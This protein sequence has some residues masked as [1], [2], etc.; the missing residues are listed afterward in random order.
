MILENVIQ[1]ST[2][3]PAFHKYL[4]GHLEKLENQVVFPALRLQMD[5]SK[6]TNNPCESMN[7][8]LK[9]EISWQPKSAVELI[10]ILQQHIRA[11]YVDLQFALFGLSSLKLAQEI[12]DKFHIDSN[13]F[14]RKSMQQ[15]VSHMKRFFKYSQVL[16]QQENS[17]FVRGQSGLMVRNRPPVARKPSTSGIS[18]RGI[19][20]ITPARLHQ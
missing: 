17:G 14:I 18:P 9:R 8:V 2:E 6:V 20:T 12:Y 4:R 5:V 1:N 11:Q 16:P 15:Q 10:T 19:R 13:E 7:H 3:S